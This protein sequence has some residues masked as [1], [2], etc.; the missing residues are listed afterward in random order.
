MMEPWIWI[1]FPVVGG[2]IGYFTNWLAVKMLFRPRRP[3]RLLGWKLQGVVPRRQGDLARKVARTVEKD[4]ISVDEIQALVRD[5]ANSER[6][7]NLLRERIDRQIAEQLERFGPIVA[8]L[9]PDDF[10]DKMKARIEREVFDFVEGLGEELHGELGNHLDVE[11]MVYKRIES[12]DVG[13]LERIVHEIARKELRH[14]EILGGILGAAIGLVQ[15]AI[16]NYFGGQ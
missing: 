5:L 3:I 13:R 15:A 1:V 10:I 2:L 8:A 12:F 14:I 11:S 9:L 4:L 7:H 6:V 16:V